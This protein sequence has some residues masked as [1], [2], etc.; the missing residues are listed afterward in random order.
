MTYNVY[1]KL[2]KYIIDGATVAIA[3]FLAYQIRFEGSIPAYFMVQFWTLF[4]LLVVGRLLTNTLF[5]VYRR[6]WH[7][8]SILDTFHL[9]QAYVTCS[10]ILLALRLS[11]PSHW[12]LFRIPISVIA[13]ELLVSL[14]GALGVR[15]LRRILQHRNSHPQRGSEPPKRVLLLGAGPAGVHTAKTLLSRPDRKLIGFLDDNPKKIGAMICGIPVLGPLDDLQKALEK[16]HADEVI[17]CISRAPREALKRIW[18]LCDGLDVRTLIVPGLDEMIDGEVQVRSLRQVSMEDLLNRETIGRL[19]EESKASHRYKGKRILITGA[20]GSIGSELA[21]QIANLAPSHL[22]LMDKDENGLYELQLQFADRI[23]ELHFELI[24]GD[25]RSPERVENIFR[26]YRPE[27]IF[28]AAAHKHV[29]LME[30]NAAEA[31]LNNV[32]GTKN[33]IEH[34]IAYGT[35]LFVLISTDKAVKPSS[36]MGAT[37]RLAELLVQSMCHYPGTKLACVR[38]GNVM[39]SRGSVI[40]LFQRQIAAGGPIT[41]TD[42]EVSRYL[43]TIPEAVRLVI[44]AGDTKGE[45]GSIYVLNMGDPIRIIDLARDLIELSGLRPAHDIAIETIG[46]RPGEKLREE[47]VGDGETLVATEDSMIL[48]IKPAAY[49]Q[50]DWLKDLLNRLWKAAQAENIEQIYRLLEECNFDFKRDKVDSEEYP[51]LAEKIEADRNA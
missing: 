14:P 3:L 4:P 9:I 11:L 20:G 48:A 36:V 33:I 35:S 21:R 27:I 15:T 38:F 5:G 18:R 7:F 49:P 17:V 42:P 13:V 41:I 47:L 23:P 40:P 24:V 12:N 44:Q 26:Q 43:M 34:A 1:S 25:I 39:S 50:T 29:P 28:H 51:T 10:V 45:N 6:V 46:L 22:L 16:Y 2:N 32:F 8:V 30:A 31:V 19:P 37:K